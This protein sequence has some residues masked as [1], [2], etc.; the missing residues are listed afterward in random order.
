MLI[1]MINPTVPPPLQQEE[2][3]LRNA[4]KAAAIAL[5]G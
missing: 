4:V 2:L 1:D 5:H 3:A